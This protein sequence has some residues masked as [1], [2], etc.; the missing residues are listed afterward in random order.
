[1]SSTLLCEYCK[2][3]NVERRGTREREGESYFRIK[4]KSDE[5]GKWGRAVDTYEVVPTFE[6]TDAEIADFLDSEIF[7]ITCAQNN[8][9]LDKKAWQAVQQ[10]AK[11]RKAQVIVIPILYR[12]PT[13]PDELASKEAWWPP[14][15]EPYLMQREIKLA[16]HIRVIGD[17]R[18]GAAAVNPLTGFESLTGPD[19]A[20][21]GHPQISMRTVPTPQNKLPKILQTTGSVS[22][23]N[24]SKSAAG[25]RGA[26][27]HSLGFTIVEV[28]KEYRLFH[29]R[30]VVGD[31]DSEFY[32]I[33][34]H[35]TARGVKKINKIPAIVL[36]DAHGDKM[37]P[38]AR[39]ATFEGPDSMVQTLHPEYLIWHDIGGASSVSHW[40]REKP[41]IRYGKHSK[42]KD[43]LLDEMCRDAK[44]L[45]DLTPS[46]SQSVV[47][48][49]NHEDH[50]KRWLEEVDWRTEP[51]NAQIY[52]KLWTAW[53]EA[54]DSG[55][56]E[57]FHPYRWWM[58]RNCNANALFLPED[59]PFIVKGIYLSYHGH[60][61]LNGARG[62]I[63]SFAKIGAKVVTGHPHSP[64]VE[65]GAYQVGTLT[66]LRDDYTQGPGSWLNTNCFV[67]P[68][69]KR[70]L[71][72]V[73]HGD[74]HY[75]GRNHGN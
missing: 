13:C 41:S 11:A 66:A 39:A 56:G 36:A 53:L 27:H 74:W 45:E 17:A 42:G 14:E 2:S 38:A 49:S 3:N 69:G 68:N 20:I 21:F 30:S 71:A 55:D 7:I 24:Y 1:M 57:T 46:F 33:N 18:I 28:D 43:R 64:G 40:H 12:N 9:P 29:V 19:S 37:D 58:G 5:C 62:N 54:I 75:D 61:G 70:Q 48:A 59:Y 73:I 35:I 60:R 47:V 22:Q 72:H 31:K 63:R 8:T 65:K 44:M 52:H 26:H 4:C 67:H 23:K 51:W 50:I 6:R 16:P 25:K 34:Y 32:D 10:Y 15:V